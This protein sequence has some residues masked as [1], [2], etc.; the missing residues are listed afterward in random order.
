MQFT[1]GALKIATSI[2]EEATA[3]SSLGIS[4]ILPGYDFIIIYFKIF[5]RMISISP[6]FTH[7]NKVWGSV[8]GNGSQFINLI[9]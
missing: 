6:G 4:A 1:L 8:I 2:D 9:Y 3:D 5:F 7:T